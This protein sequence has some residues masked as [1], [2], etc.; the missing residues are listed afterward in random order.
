MKRNVFNGLRE[1]GS[2]IHIDF[3]IL[4]DSFGQIIV[5]KLSGDFVPLNCQALL[6]KIDPV[7]VKTSYDCNCSVMVEI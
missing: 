2:L 1:T 5:V 7:L 3:V 4:L 6:S